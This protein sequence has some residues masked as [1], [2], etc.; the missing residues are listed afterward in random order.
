MKKTLNNVGRPT[1]FTEVILQKLE[2]AF[3]LDCTDEEACF[4]ANISP[5]SLYN[6]QKENEEFLERKKALKQNPIIKARQEV[7]KG[8]DGNPELALKYLE[9]KRRDEFNPKN[10]VSME[11]YDTL[12]TIEWVIPEGK[13]SPAVGDKQNISA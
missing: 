3:L 7:I 11:G 8:M 10:T 2:G 9:R 5:S 12:R 13:S 4:V 1:I 6:Y